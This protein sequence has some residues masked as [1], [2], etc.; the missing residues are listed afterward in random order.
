ME[1]E[2][3][4]PLHLCWRSLLSGSGERADQ[5]VDPPERWVN[6]LA[7]DVRVVDAVEAARGGVA[8]CAVVRCGAVECQAW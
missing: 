3:N 5:C 6:A 7:G 2:K 1:A 8:A 4:A